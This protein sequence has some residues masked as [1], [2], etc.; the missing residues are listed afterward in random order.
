S[1]QIKTG[2]SVNGDYLLKYAEDVADEAKKI[3]RAFAFKMVDKLLAR[4]RSNVN[5][6]LKEL[7]TTIEQNEGVIRALEAE[8]RL[9]QAEQH[10]YEQL[11]SI[12][13]EK[14]TISSAEVADALSSLPAD[15]QVT[16]VHDEEEINASQQISE[17]ELQ[18]QPNHH[19]KSVRE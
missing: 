10:I 8:K 13:L 11:H 7:K 9:Q 17:R 4:L 14:S 18:S 6:E 16:I 5:D 3:Y 19:E 1:E 15:P 2:A 12:L